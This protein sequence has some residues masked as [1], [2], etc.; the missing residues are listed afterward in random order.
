MQL[1]CNI[2]LFYFNKHNLKQLI[3][4][5]YNNIYSFDQESQLFLKQISFSFL[6]FN[7]IQPDILK[8]VNPPWQP[9]PFRSFNTKALVLCVGGQ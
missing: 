7:Q 9:P 1:F 5:S 4:R 6:G 2:S 3:A 8:T